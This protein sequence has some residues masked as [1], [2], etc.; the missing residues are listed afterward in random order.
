MLLSA[1][2]AVSADYASLYPHSSHGYGQG[3]GYGSGY[4]YG[5]YGADYLDHYS[6]PYY[7]P[8]VVKAVAPVATS[9]ANVYKANTPSYPVHKSYGQYS[10][11]PYYKSYAYAAPA[12]GYSHGYDS[13]GYGYGHQDLGYGYGVGHGAGYG[14]GGYGYGHGL[15]AA[16]YG[17]GLGYGYGGYLH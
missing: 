8:T 2:A 13:L 9:Y 14:Y 16:S 17:H 5:T 12:Y 3:Y 4:G 1:V 7:A 11:S 10:S 6:T 15:G